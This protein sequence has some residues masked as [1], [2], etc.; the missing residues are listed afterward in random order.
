MIALLVVTILFST[1]VSAQSFFSS[2]QEPVGLLTTIF[3]SGNLF[4]FLAA[5]F[6]SS[7][8]VMRIISI[9]ATLMTARYEAIKGRADKIIFVICAMLTF[10]SVAYPAAYLIRPAFAVVT[11]LGLIL[12]YSLTEILSVRLLKKGADVNSEAGT[13]A[14][15]YFIVSIFIA[16]V[17]SLAERANI[18]TVLVVHGILSGIIYIGAHRVLEV[19]SR[20]VERLVGEKDRGKREREHAEKLALVHSALR[21]GNLTLDAAKDFLGDSTKSIHDLQAVAMSASLHGLLPIM[22]KI[23]NKIPDDFVQI[24]PLDNTSTAE[25][26]QEVERNIEESKRAI[27]VLEK[28]YGSTNAGKESAYLFSVL[29]DFEESG[30]EN[31][32]KHVGKEW[33]KCDFADAVEEFKN[34]KWKETAEKF[35]STT[36]NGG[37]KQAIKFI[38]KRL[39]ELRAVRDNEVSEIKESIT[40]REKIL[41][42]ETALFEQAYTKITA[43]NGV[44]TQYHELVYQI[45]KELAL[46]RNV[47]ATALDEEQDEGSR[48][49]ALTTSIPTLFFSIQNKINNLQQYIGPLEKLI[50]DD[51]ELTSRLIKLKKNIVTLQEIR[52][53]YD[54]AVPEEEAA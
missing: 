14:A 12:S 18:F 5:W 47:F 21:S 31:W 27:D 19:I 24:E 41:Q 36:K 13:I 45:N 10:Y 44:I 4:M 30:N 23:A 15:T 51:E 40:D 7:M 20:H 53:A 25:R 32:V 26:I 3:K 11:W 37:K 28:N 33:D 34:Q 50:K 42:K 17:V 46:L 16:P 35:R 48:R 49:R 9:F 22:R 39:A 8:L 43:A 38:R 2:I 6:G 54:Y 29:K 1:T 52:A